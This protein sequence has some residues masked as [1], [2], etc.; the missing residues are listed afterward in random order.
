MT[1]TQLVPVC[2]TVCWTAT[3]LSWGHILCVV[4]VIWTPVHSYHGKHSIRR[5][6]EMENFVMTLLLGLV[7]PTSIFKWYVYI[8]IESVDSICRDSVDMY[9]GVNYVKYNVH[10]ISNKF[11][12]FFGS[13]LPSCM[14]NMPSCMHNLPSCSMNARYAIIHAQYAIMHA[15]Y[16]IIHAQLATCSMLCHHA[17]P[18]CHHP[19][20]TCHHTYI[21]CLQLHAL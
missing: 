17:C 2:G 13:N 10:N 19:C 4:C 20:T 12:T 18:I 7:L 9:M 5:F 3:A 11:I 16:A 14:H 1:I 21:T 15:Q 6:W 8:I